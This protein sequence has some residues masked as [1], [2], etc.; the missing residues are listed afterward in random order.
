MGHSAMWRDL[1]GARVHL[2]SYMCPA[3]HCKLQRSRRCLFRLVCRLFMGWPSQRPLPGAQPLHALHL[4]PQANYT[5]REIRVSTL[6]MFDILLN[7]FRCDLVADIQPI[8]Y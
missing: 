8:Q 7:V 6:R 4:S 3:L 5:A 1:H 2:C